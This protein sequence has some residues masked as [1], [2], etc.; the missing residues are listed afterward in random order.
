MSGYACV[1]GSLYADGP[2]QGGGSTAVKVEND[3]DEL[4]GC[5]DEA[6][7]EK[8]GADVLSLAEGNRRDGGVGELG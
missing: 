1:I 2:N 7:E 5:A 6:V 3:A 8:Q 4:S